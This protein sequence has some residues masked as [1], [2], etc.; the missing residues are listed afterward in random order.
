[1]YMVRGSGRAALA[2]SS[3]AS[4]VALGAG[5]CSSPTPDMETLSSAETPI[6]GG[7]LD[8]THKGV[9]SLLKQVE[10]GFYPSCSG[11]LLTQ[12]LVLT[13]HH[14]VAALNSD[15][16]AS[17]E[18]GKTQFRDADAASTMLVS[19]EANVGQEGLNPYRVDQVWVAERGSPVCGKDIALL[20]LSGS[21]IPAT[22]AKPIEPG[23]TTEVKPDALFA[24][25]GYG[26]QDPNDQ[27]GETAGH[28][29]GVDDAQVFCAG[30]ACDTPMV[31]ET[32]WIAESPVCSGDSGGPALD[33]AGRV[34]GVTS[35]GDPDCTIGIYSSVYAW[36]DFIVKGAVDAAAAGNYSPPPWAGGPV[37]P[38][39]GTGG[40]GGAGGR[41]G[42]GGS[43]S[44]GASGGG[45]GTAPDSGVAGVPTFAGMSVGG[46]AMSPQ[47]D[48]LGLSCNGPCPG[49]YKCW[50]ETGQPPGICVPACSATAPTCPT[51]FTCSPQVQS[52]VPSDAV[53][54]S[55]ATDSS[56]CSVSAPASGSVP[57]PA[58][59]WL[60]VAAL[61]GSLKR[62]RRSLRS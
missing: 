14:C 51:G 32:E 62:F 58:W 57:T 40:S 34:V 48:P 43:S 59:L 30:S 53:K 24:A 47:V 13:A 20:L 4:V 54:K 29:M 50:A 3:L 42:G 56:G 9:V 23:L 35:R 17:V 38:N 60:G 55:S 26:L 37:N 7:T 33:Q 16:G 46:Q 25:I 19:V 31:T 27:R 6:I 10:G 39:P 8:T 2:L 5:G 52:C 22:V 28:R 49:S 61:F 12:N 15:D 36:R 11:T 45:G 1:M 41:G 44:G 18:C 21:G